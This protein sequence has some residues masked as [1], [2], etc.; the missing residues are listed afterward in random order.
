MVFPSLLTSL[1]LFTPDHTATRAGRATSLFSPYPHRILSCSQATLRRDGRAAC[2][3]GLGHDV[4][5]RRRPGSRRVWRCAHAYACVYVCMYIYICKCISVYL[6]IYLS[7]Y[8]YFYISIYLSICLSIYIHLSIYLYCICI[9]IYLFLYINTHI[10]K[11]SRGGLGHA[12]PPR[13]RPGSC[14]LWRYAHAYV[15]MHVCMYIYV[16]VYVYVYVCMY[17]YLSFYLSIYFF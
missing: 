16:Y 10:Y 14:R 13:Q 2:R 6:S 1:S 8:L 5:P 3:G 9:Y 4:S 12:A 17:I 11:Y 7:I 15:C